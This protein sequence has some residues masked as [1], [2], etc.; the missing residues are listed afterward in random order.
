MPAAKF[1]PGVPPGFQIVKNFWSRCGSVQDPSQF[2]APTPVLVSVSGVVRPLQTLWAKTRQ[3]FPPWG[4]NF[5]ILDWARCI[6]HPARL[7]PTSWGIHPWVGAVWWGWGRLTSFRNTGVQSSSCN[8]RGIPARL[9]E[10]AWRG[11]L[12]YGL[13]CGAH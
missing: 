6:N 9:P 13:W 8:V 11:D 5:Y 3:G 2:P 1:L 12:L 4:Q 10:A 7:R